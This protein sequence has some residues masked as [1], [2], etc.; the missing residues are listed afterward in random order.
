[1]SGVTRKPESTRMVTCECGQEDGQ[2]QMWE[3][4]EAMREEKN[5]LFPSGFV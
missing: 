5:R 1:M 4:N 3:E 2:K